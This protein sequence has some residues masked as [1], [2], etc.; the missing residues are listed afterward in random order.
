MKKFLIFVLCLLLQTGI[1]RAEGEV[2]HSSSVPLRRVILFSSGVGYFEHDGYVKGNENLTLRFS[3][4]QINDVLKSIVVMDFDGGTVAGIEYPSNEPLGRLLEGFPVNLEKDNSLFKILDKLRGERVQVVVKNVES[5]G[6]I[7]GIER[8]KGKSGDIFY[9]TLLS[10]KGFRRIDLSKVESI[11]FL[12][13]KIDSEIRNELSL[14]SEKRNNGGRNLTV[15]FVG[16]GRRRV[17][18]AYLVESPLWKTTYRLVI[19]DNEGREALIQGWA[20]VENMSGED[21]KGVNLSLVAG[22]P[23]SFIM[24]LYSPI[25]V[26]RPVVSLGESGNIKPGSYEGGIREKKAEAEKIFSPS[27]SSRGLSMDLTKGIETAVRTHNLGEFFHYTVTLPISILSHHSAMIPIVN[28]KIKIERVS[29]YNDE[30]NKEHPLSGVKLI[31]D[32]GLYLK[33]GP[34]TVFED[35]G[36]AGDAIFSSLKSGEDSFVS[37]AVDVGTA[38]VFRVSTS[39]RSI[40]SVKIINGNVIT[41]KVEQRITTYRFLN[42]DKRKKRLIVE[43]RVDPYWKIVEPKKPYEVTENYNRF[44]VDLPPWNGKESPTIYR[45]VEEHVLRETVGLSSISRGMIGVFLSSNEISPKIK[46]VFKR[47]SDIKLSISKLEGEY[48]ALKNRYSTIEADQKRIREN[49][50]SLDKESSLYKR[51]VK[52][53]NSE[54]DEVEKI[55]AARDRIS[56][57]LE[58]KKRELMGFIASIRIE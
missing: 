40:N 21:W 11:L 20:I 13:G 38:V 3:R 46:K 55:L 37:Y 17:R 28:R 27:V 9:L 25:Y 39:G 57:E 7:V 49:L 56:S 22:R 33:G 34:V 2:E 12:D 53:L 54:E 4:T 10:D 23:I 16:N 51:Y 52:R 1:M 15:R 58:A 6:R 18:I 48:D 43:K 50:K 24:D 14:I 19:G 35:G 26:K 47:L 42:R 5:I 41:R 32:T 31:N 36:Y 45:V 29:I 44:V 8:E 30:V